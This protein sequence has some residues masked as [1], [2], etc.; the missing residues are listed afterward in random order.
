MSQRAVPEGKFTTFCLTCQFTCHEVCAY[1]DDN[2]KADCTAMT[3]GQCTMCKNKCHWTVHKNA[4]WILYPEEVT[5]TITSKELID[6]WNEANNTQEGVL[7]KLLDDYL[8][9]QETL[10]LD[11]MD[12]AGLNDQLNATA[13]LHDSTGLIHYVDVLITTAKTQNAPAEY[14]IQLNTARN[15]LKLLYELKQKNKQVGQD[16]KILVDVLADVR[17]EMQRRM[18]MTAEN[19]AAE[20]RKPCSLYNDLRQKLPLDLM[21]KAPPPL[22]TESATSKGALYEENLKVVVILVRL[23]PKDGGVVAALASQAS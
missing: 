20:E 23:V 19:R 21:N 11:M 1:G 18:S 2:Q 7:I 10:R 15:T 16:L 5:E 22:K 8:K 9:Q 4:K 6:K 14:L 13:L 3:N 12:L 17:N